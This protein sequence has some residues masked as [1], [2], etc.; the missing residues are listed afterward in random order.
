MLV[1][2]VIHHPKLLKQRTKFFNFWFMFSS[3]ALSCLTFC[4]P[5]GLSSPWNS[6]GQNTGVGSLSLLQ[7]IFPTR[8]SN[9]GFPHCGR[10]LY[11]LNHKGSPSLCAAHK[12]SPVSVLFQ[13]LVT[14]ILIPPLLSQFS[15]QEKLRWAQ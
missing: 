1:S 5:H 13:S 4:D 12:Q 15:Q 11:Y 9:P 2:Y 10:I 3:V 7:G 8:G 14:Y 6:P